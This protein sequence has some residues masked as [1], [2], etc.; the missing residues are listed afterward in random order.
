MRLNDLY[1]FDEEKKNRKRIGRGS[2]SG[3]GCT[4][5]KG[6]KGQ[7]ARAGGTKRPGFEGGQMPLARR[8]P[9]RGFKN[10]LFK[11]TYAPMNLGRLLQAFEGKSEITLDD[12]Y[13]AGLCK[14][15]ALVKVLGD[16]ELTNAVTIE[17]HKFSSQAKA[18]IEAAGGAAKA[19]LAKEEG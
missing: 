11:T 18:K 1:P 16:G 19:F 9:K 6:N 15:G 14:Q 8:L 17:A 5:G 3:W 7:K 13:A 4:A 10:A 12:I 2:G